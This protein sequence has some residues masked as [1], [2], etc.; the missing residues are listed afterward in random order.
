[1]R[2][3]IKDPGRISH[4]LEMAKLIESEKSRH[5]YQELCSDKILFYGLSK[6]VEIIGEARVLQNY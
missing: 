5:T 1:M 4:M 3:P 6:M 2:D